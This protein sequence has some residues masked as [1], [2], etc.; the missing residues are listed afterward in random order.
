MNVH[1][2]IYK[3]NGYVYVWGCNHHGQLGLGHNR[4]IIKPILLMNNKK[5]KQISLGVNY[6]IFHEHNGDIY[7]FEIFKLLKN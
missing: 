7:V 3:Q 1:N 6:S 4:N 5:I 2:I